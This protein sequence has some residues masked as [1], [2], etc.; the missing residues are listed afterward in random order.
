M[1]SGRHSA[2][3]RALSAAASA[4]GSPEP[5]AVATAS[6]LRASE[7]R[8]VRRVVELDREP[9]LQAGA[10]EREPS[11]RL[12]RL[13]QPRDRLGVEVDDRDA[14]A[15][16]AERGL[17]QQRGIAA[18]AGEP[19]GG[20]E[21]AARARG[22]ARAQQRVAAGE[23][24]RAGL[25]FGVGERERLERALEAL[26]GVLVGEP[27]ERAAAG[28][29]E[30]VGDLA[31]VG[32]RRGLEQLGGDLLQVAVL[33]QRPQRLRGAAVQPRAAQ[34]VEL[35][36][37]RLAHERVRELEAPAGRGA[38]QQPRAQHLV[39]R[40]LGGGGLERR[41]AGQRAR[42]ELEPE[43]RGGGQ[44]LVGGLARA[45]TAGR[46]PRGARSPGTSGL[47]ASPRST[48][49]AKNALPSVRACTC[50][51]KRRPTSVALEAASMRLSPGSSSRARAAMSS[52]RPLSPTRS[53]VPSR[54]SSASAPVSGLWRPSSVSR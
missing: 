37:D 27:L 23:Q 41:G 29:D 11:R 48:C 22:V 36:V 53:S 39:E 44:Q 15:G 28:A 3:W 20:V 12:E 21:G 35:V 17:R 19:G 5:R 8:A 26:G 42:V 47:S 49:S 9:R 7:R 34:H 24:D 2:T 40:R 4:L 32:G 30:Q 25:V 46:R 14:E 54:C 43:H 33:A 18:P 6:A 52:S 45:A 16:E 51:A 31:R 1:R 13:L 50:A 10:H 38:P